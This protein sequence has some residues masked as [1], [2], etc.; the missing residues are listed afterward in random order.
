MF[1][2]ISQQFL[3]LKFVN[4]LVGNRWLQH[5]DENNEQQKN[6]DKVCKFLYILHWAIQISSCEMLKLPIK[7]EHNDQH[8]AFVTWSL[9]FQKPKYISERNW[10]AQI[11]NSV[12]H[13]LI[14]VIERQ[15]KQI[16]RSI[17]TNKKAV[18]LWDTFDKK[19][20]K[21]IY[22]RFQPKCQ[23]CKNEIEI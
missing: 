10:H 19:W 3:S 9:S 6:S 16:L 15:C 17:L 8:D 2:Y 23:N 21:W 4:N 5:L 20:R 1:I 7:I 11:T 13:Y 12:I 22:V 14:H 18:L